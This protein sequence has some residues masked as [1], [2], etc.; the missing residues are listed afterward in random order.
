MFFVLAISKVS[1]AYDEVSINLPDFREDF[2]QS[3][4]KYY[5]VTIQDIDTEPSEWTVRVTYSDI[6][7]ATGY[8]ERGVWKFDTGYCVG[9]SEI[10][11]CSLNETEFSYNATTTDGY[12]GEKDHETYRLVYSNTDLTYEGDVVFQQAPTHSTGAIP[13]TR[14]QVAKAL[15]QVAYLLPCLIGSLIGLVALKKSYN[16]LRTQLQI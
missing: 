13:I 9:A 7:V 5:Y 8:R 2:E 3:G 4:Y 10:H 6:N 14:F 12:V 16:W 1:Y 11:E 15:K